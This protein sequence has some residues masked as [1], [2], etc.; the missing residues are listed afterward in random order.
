MK[1][2]EMRKRVKQIGN[3]FL[4][5]LLAALLI[6]T[7]LPIGAVP[8]QAATSLGT[9][10][11]GVEKFTIGQGWLVEPCLVDIQPGDNYAALLKRVLG[12]NGYTYTNTGMNDEG[13]YLAGI[14]HADSGV[15]HIPDCIQKLPQVT[16]SRDKLIPH[17]TD[18]SVNEYKNGKDWL[19][20][21]S[22]NQMAGWMYSLNNVLANTGM[23]NLEPQNGDVFRVQFTVYGYGL[24]LQGA[25]QQGEYYPVGNKTDLFAK[26]A[27]INMNQEAWFAID[28]CKAAYEKALE[29]LMKVDAKQEDIDAALKALPD[30]PQVLPEEVSFDQEEAELIRGEALQLVA[31]IEPDSAT[32]LSLT[33]DSTQPSVADVDAS[34]TVQAL[35]PGETD[36]TATA[37]GGAKALC[38]VTVKDRLITKINLNYSALSLMTGDSVKL[39][40]ESVEPSNATE[41]RIFNYAYDNDCIELTGG[42]EGQTGMTVTAVSEGTA[43]ITVSVAGGASAICQVTV[44]DADK[45]AA[46]M[47][48]KISGLPEADA[49]DE[50]NAYDVEA[51]GREYDSLPEAVKAKIDD[52]AKQKLESSR[53]AA[54]KVLESLKNV[55]DVLDRLHALPALSKLTYADKEAVQQA[56]DAYEQL[57][58]EE[59]AKIGEDLLSRL[60]T[61]EKAIADL[62]NQLAE[63]KEM[64]EK[65]PESGSTDAEDALAAW[66]AYR[67]LDAAQKEAL[68]TDA[69]KVEQAAD[70]LAGYVEDGVKAVAAEGSVDLDSQEIRKFLL[71][72]SLYEEMEELTERVSPDA[73]SHL[74]AVRSWIGDGI[75][76]DGDVSME[77]SWF[78]SLNAAKR[79]NAAERS[80]LQKAAKKK[81]PDME[82]IALYA[83]LGYTDIRSGAPYTPEKAVPLCI[84]APGMNHPMAF[85]V[86]EKGGAYTF[87]EV[88]AAYEAGV[89]SIETKKTGRILILDVPVLATGVEAPESVTVGIAGSVQLEAKALPADATKNTGLSYKSADGAIVRVSQDGVLTGVKAGTATVTVSL[90]TDPSKAAKCRVTVTDKANSTAK[91][92]SQVMR[93]A[94]AYMLSVDKN[95]TIGSEWFAL[96]LARGGKS[97]NDAY[98]KTYYNHTANYLQEKK[99]ILTNTVKYTEYSKTILAMTAIG[100]DAANIAGYNLFEKLSDFDAV[101]EQGINGPIWALIAVNAQEKYDFPQ[102]SGGKVQTTKQKLIDYILAAECKGGGWNLSGS[103]GDPDMTGMALQALAP[104]YKKAGYEKV[105]AAIDRALALLSDIQEADGGFST[106]GSEASESCAQVLTALCSLGID[107]ETDSRFIKN[108]HWLV[109]NLLTFQV[110]D[111]GFMH[112]KPGSDSNGGGAAGKLNGMATEQAYYALVSYQRLKDGKTALYDMNDL[113]VAAGGKGDGSG[114]GLENGGGNNSGTTKP[115]STTKKPGGSGTTLSSGSSTKLS[116]SAS[117]T[118]K[119]SS[120]VTKSAGS[121]IKSTAARISG[122]GSDDAAASTGGWSFDGEDYEAGSA[123]SADGVSSAYGMTIEDGEVPLSGPGSLTLGEKLFNAGTLPYLLCILAGAGVLGYFGWTYYKKKRSQEV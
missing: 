11:I 7:A 110:G 53:A 108:G 2:P 19:G 18:E 63:A 67:D 15:I 50:G 86:T 80:A 102:V 81:Y 24:D 26:I 14:D 21:F 98:F 121:V 87:D 117:G 13:F 25:D 75:H 101:C 58:E 39:D 79:N 59:Q 103:T 113:T 111:E 37:N 49:V 33:W 42:G 91:S 114:T 62:E 30:G 99:G 64:I 41:D 112:V 78:V 28:G 84:K 70:A 71:C 97:L 5:A 4:C 35:S 3:R 115:G 92:V 90:R 100:K 74:E 88:S 85:L 56:R 116:S 66:K 48:E 43:S 82:G 119:T 51:A 93:E 83:D 16:D 122:S 34:G 105:T 94:S 31:R 22:Y 55:A 10:A 95:P 6:G 29:Q 20:E 120:A 47:T 52:G 77:G 69:D 45:L 123:Y 9:V 60:S 57:T 44:A 68:G 118:K 61:L 106:M 54:A 104:Y 73:A 89:I 107:P 36:I 27:R 65:L 46:A 109:E 1:R 17:P 23:G 40:V 76:T 38:H 8:V 96:G 72:S 32:D 12:Q